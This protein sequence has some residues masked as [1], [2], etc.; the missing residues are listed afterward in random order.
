[1]DT[2][3]RIVTWNCNEGF[4][5]KYKKIQEFDAD[6]YIIQECREPADYK[7]HTDKEFLNFIKNSLWTG[8]LQKK[9]VEGV[10]NGIGI[11]AMKNHKISDNYWEEE[12]PG[13]YISCCIDEKINLLAVWPQWTEEECCATDFSSYLE[14]YKESID[15]DYII[16]GDFNIDARY[17]HQSNECKIK[18]KKFFENL[19]E[20]GLFSAYHE[21]FS[22][23][24]GVETRK[25]FHFAKNEKGTSHLDYLFSNK[26]RIIKVELGDP[27]IWL[28]YSDHVPLIVDLK[29]E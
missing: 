28:K 13:H 6:L 24:H 25:T 26:A 4:S 20:K 14:K 27:K 18:S 16:A 2:F 11:F 15:S 12:N 22:E 23:D 3:L 8:H 7:D 17:K 5:E 1:M 10:S 19:N 21:F 9:S 29:I